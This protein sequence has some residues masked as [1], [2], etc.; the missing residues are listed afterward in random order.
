[1]NFKEDKR[2]LIGNDHGGYAA[3]V[4]I[5]EH[6]Q[7]KGYAVNNLGADDE[8]IVRYPNYVREVAGRIS[9]GEYQKGILLCSTGIG[10]SIAANKYKGVRA[11]V[12][13]SHYEAQ[14][15]RQHNNSNILCLGGKTNGI[16]DLLDFVDTWLENEYIGGRHEISLGIIEDIEEEL[17]IRSGE[18]QDSESTQD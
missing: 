13:N 14:M 2:I 8:E 12:V 7:K 10:M 1:M 4:K 16:F 11:A 17:G 3:K 5:L 9:R 6:L 18:A 15:T